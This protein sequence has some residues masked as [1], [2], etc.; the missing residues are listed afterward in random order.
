M[1]SPASQY[2]SDESDSDK[3]RLAESCA[4]LLRKA[5]K[6][7]GL[8]VPDLAMAQSVLAISCAL[9][10]C[11]FWAAAVHRASKTSGIC[12]P[13]L[14]MAQSV[15]ARSCALKSCNFACEALQSG[16]KTAESKR[17]TAI[18]WM[19]IT[20]LRGEKSAVWDPKIRKARSSSKRTRRSIGPPCRR[21]I[22]LKAVAILTSLNSCN[23]NSAIPS[24]ADTDFARLRPLLI[25]KFASDLPSDLICYRH[26]GQ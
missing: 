26:L 12:V 15:L 13:V 9:K 11:T 8:R 4:A 10:S 14:A 25:A 7:S 3:H 16:S 1:G 20:R 19:T 17:S 18:A 22:W 21:A 6:T 2:L 23:R 5:S 24:T